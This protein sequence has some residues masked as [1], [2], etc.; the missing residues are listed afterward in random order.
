MSTTE[1]RQKVVKSH[2]R[3]S[4]DEQCNL[5][6]IHR[7]GIYYK[8]QGESALNLQLMKIIDEYFMEHPYFGVERMT[9][10]LRLDKGFK[11]NKK[12]IRRLYRLMGIQTIYPKRKTTIH[13]KGRHIYPYL[14]RNMK[15][16]RPNQ[17]WQT[18]IS[19]IPMYKGFM[20]LA[21]IIDVKSRKILNW[22]IS[23]SMTA[24]WCVELLEDTIQK[25]GA[26]EIHNSDQGSQYTSDIYINTLKQNKIKISMDGKDLRLRGENIVFGYLNKIYIERFWRSIK[27]E[28]IYLNPPNGGLDLYE[29]VK[30]YISF[31]NTKRRHT[32]IGKVPPNEIFYQKAIAC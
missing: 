27:Q 4:L 22:S 11:V 23:N 7:S 12:R 29:K 13:Q 17:V 32:E 2:P 20:Y 15:I 30:E 18:D 19:Y 21:A 31:Y 25:H 24:E 3:L 14:L 1:K 10:Y 16:E 28:K 6:T 9:D 5:L 8:P 26:P